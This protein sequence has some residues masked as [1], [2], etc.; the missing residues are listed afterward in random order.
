L[1]DQKSIVLYLGMKEIAL[2]AIH[3]DFVRTLGEDDVA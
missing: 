2:N 3:D 1:T